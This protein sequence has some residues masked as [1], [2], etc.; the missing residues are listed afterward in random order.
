MPGRGPIPAIGENGDRV[1]SL[2]NHVTARPGV[3]RE[4]VAHRR[5]RTRWAEGASLGACKAP[6]SRVLVA[7]ASVRRRW[8][9]VASAAVVAAGAASA[10]T[11][12][13][14]D[15]RRK[16]QACE[17]ARE[18]LSAREFHLLPLP[19]ASDLARRSGHVESN[20]E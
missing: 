11:E 12:R 1:R 17:D 9:L 10:V 13:G 19:S 5:H 7:A 3:D 14:A 18:D 4:D 6:P 15:G 2:S 8:R 16:R 20:A